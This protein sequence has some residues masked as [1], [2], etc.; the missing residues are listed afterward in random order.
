MTISHIDESTNDLFSTELALR[1][2]ALGFVSTAVDMS[3][4]EIESEISNNVE[5]LRVELNKFSIAYFLSAEQVIRSELPSLV[6]GLPSLNASRDYFA[7]IQRI[8]MEREF[9]TKSGK[10]LYVIIVGP[11][12]FYE[13]KSRIVLKGDFE[14]DTYYARKQFSTMER[15]TL[16]LTNPFSHTEIKA[17]KRPTL[18]CEEADSA[19][20]EPTILEHE[21]TAKLGHA[22]LDALLQRLTSQSDAQAVKELT[23]KLFGRIMAAD[24]CM[25]WEGDLPLLGRLSG[26]N[27]PFFLASN[28]EKTALAFSLFLAL[29][30]AELSEGCCLGFYS[31][32]NG[33]DNLRFL[34]AMDCLRDFILSTNASIFFKTAKSN[35]RLLAESR[36]N[37][38]INSVSIPS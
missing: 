25:T 9:L 20:L 35:Y 21:V 19:Y 5:C 23:S 24:H 17:H 29:E 15:L 34:A 28:G 36:L 14:F 22:D 38:A 6:S 27:P 37:K 32:L 4:L 10:D 26:H 31:A 1:L 2:T 12:S 30:H 16:L 7:N 18:V 13:G 33:L 8:A 11:D 3:K